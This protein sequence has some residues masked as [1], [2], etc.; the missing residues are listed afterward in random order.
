MVCSQ[1]SALESHPSGLIPPK[2]SQDQVHMFI[3]AHLL[4]FSLF[5]GHLPTLLL[6]PPKT[7]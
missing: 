3:N 2:T 1:R 4:V 5:T 7:K 6:S